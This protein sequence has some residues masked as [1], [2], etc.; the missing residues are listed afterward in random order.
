GLDA[1]P[2]SANGKIDRRALPAPVLDDG[3]ELSPPQGDIEAAIAGTWGQVLGVTEI[4]RDS[5]FFE[6][7]GDSILSLQI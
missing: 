4:G 6:L 2:L 1:L 7:G 3:V 5:N